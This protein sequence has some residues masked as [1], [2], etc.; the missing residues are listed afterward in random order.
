MLLAIVALAV[1]GGCGRAAA[2]PTDS[3]IAGLVL[4]GPQ[5]PVV[6]EGEPCPDVPFEAELRVRADDGRVSTTRSGPDGRFRLE[7]APGHYVVEPVA[8]NPGAPPQ[9]S[10]VGVEVAPHA[11]TD[12]TITYDSGIR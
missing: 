11:F 5:C 10:P 7:L 1:L 4:I 6:Q 8:P 12:V 9:A 2:P 3:G